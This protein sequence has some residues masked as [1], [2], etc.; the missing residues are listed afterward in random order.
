MIKS[1]YGIMIIL[2]MIILIITYLSPDNNNY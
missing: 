2:I 1:D